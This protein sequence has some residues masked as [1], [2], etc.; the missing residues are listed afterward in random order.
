MRIGNRSSPR[1]PALPTSAKPSYA[2]GIIRTPAKPRSKLAIEKQS[3][4]ARDALRDFMRNRAPQDV[5]Q[6]NA[7][8][9]LSRIRRGLDRSSGQPGTARDSVADAARAEAQGQRGALWSRLRDSIESHF[10][11]R[12]GEPSDKG[13]RLLPEPKPEVPHP[14]K[15]AGY[16]KPDIIR[17]PVRAPGTSTR[18]IPI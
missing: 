8:D 4:H 11:D 14:I 12:R 9:A 7:R 2:K 13:D 5:S 6:P 16:L 10:R 1:P 18:T 3:P 17:T 15:V